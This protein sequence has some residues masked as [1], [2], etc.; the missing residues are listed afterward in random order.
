M[1]VQ[2]VDDGQALAR[3]CSTQGTQRAA[4]ATGDGSVAGQQVRANAAGT[5]H[6]AHFQSGDARGSLSSTS[7]G[8]VLSGQETAANDGADQGSRTAFSRQA[9]ETAMLQAAQSYLQS[10]QVQ[11]TLGITA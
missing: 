7:L 8:A 11:A 10:G 4:A 5:A 6:S 1:H 9:L 3:A 2:G